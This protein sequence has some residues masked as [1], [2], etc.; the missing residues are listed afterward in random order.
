MSTAPHAAEPATQHETHFSMQSLQWERRPLLIFTPSVNDADYRRQKDLLDGA[1]ATGVAAREI[2]VIEVIGDAASADGV[3][4]SAATAA[5][6]RQ[7]YRA[8]A[9]E[10]AVI[11]VGKDGTEKLRSTSPVPAE[12]IFGLIDSMPMRR[13]EMRQSG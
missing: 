3:D 4:V 1:A 12:D 7:K 10:L 8:P 2:V 5:E 13:Q 11:L 6:L 9:D